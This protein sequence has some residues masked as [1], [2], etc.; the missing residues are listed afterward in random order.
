MNY[1][2][3]IKAMD[4]I[5]SNYELSKLSPKNFEVYAYIL[6]Q[7]YTVE[8][9]KI[10][11]DVDY[12]DL[13]D[14]YKVTKSSIS[15]SINKLSEIGLIKTTRKRRE[16]SRF[17]LGEIVKDE[18]NF[19]FNNFISL[20]ENM[21]VIEDSKKLKDKLKNSLS[22]LY[23]TKTHKT[24]KWKKCS[25]DLLEECLDMENY[26]SENLLKYYKHFLDYGDKFANF[27][28]TDK[29]PKTFF[30][31]YHPISYLYESTI[32]LV[33][34]VEW[35]KK[36]E[37]DLEVKGFIKDYVP[38]IDLSRKLYYV[39]N[40]CDEK[41]MEKLDYYFAWFLDN[42]KNTE[43]KNYAI[44]LDLFLREYAN[45]VAIYNKIHDSEKINN[46]LTKLFA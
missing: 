14:R 4:F 41:E 23:T 33:P 42:Y 35:I 7:P 21:P 31:L 28:F 3:K 9:G 38:F 18:T 13:E 6:T 34:T 36:I 5:S 19:Y 24:F 25:I 44:S 17:I 2:K 15:V 45:I 16:K 12:K 29:T 11:S 39:S 46:D 30:T 1:T 8:D 10:I 32:D 20:R 37:K 40:K 26:N 27:R 22:K 43:Y